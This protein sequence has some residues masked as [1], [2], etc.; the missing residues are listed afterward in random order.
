MEIQD[1]EGN[2]VPGPVIVIDVMIKA[3]TARIPES[4]YFMAGIEYLTGNILFNMIHYP[5]STAIR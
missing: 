2:L 5:K 1:G 4:M 3:R